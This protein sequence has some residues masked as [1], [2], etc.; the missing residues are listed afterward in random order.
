MYPV[1]TQRKRK[2]KHPRQSSP[3]LKKP[4]TKTVEKTGDEVGGR[5]GEEHP[6]DLGKFQQAGSCRRWVGTVSQNRVRQG[7]AGGMPGTPGIKLSSGLKQLCSLILEP[8]K[9]GNW[10]DALAQEQRA[11][12]FSAEEWAFLTSR[13]L[14]Q[15]QAS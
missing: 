6:Q 12:S 15:V 4:V 2:A 14:E 3:Y 5:K 9:T 8:R 10:L 11:R 1:S 13:L 7:E